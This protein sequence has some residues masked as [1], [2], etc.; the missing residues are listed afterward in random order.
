VRLQQIVEELHVELVILYD[1]DG[2]L[3]GLRLCCE[4]WASTSVAIIFRDDL[5]TNSR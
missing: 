3:H 5:V 1:E 4:P 2:L